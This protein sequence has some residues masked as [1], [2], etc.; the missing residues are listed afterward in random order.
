MPTAAIGD[1]ARPVTP[2]PARLASAGGLALAALLYAA[3]VVYG[4]LMPFDYRPRP[5]PEALAAFEAIPYLELGV[6]SRADWVANILLYIPLAFTAMAAWS[7]AAGRRRWLVP[8]GAVL[9]AGACVALA[10]AVEFAQL[11]FP[12][13]TVS[14]ND[15]I[16][17]SIG[18]AIGIAL[19]F[20]AGPRLLALLQGLRS[21]GAVAHRALLALYVLAYFALAFFPFDLLVSRQELADK[22]AD[23]TRVA[24]GVAG[25]C[26]GALVC[27]VKLGTELLIAAPIG[28]LLAL[29]LPRLGLGAAIAVGLALGAVVEAGQLLLASGVTQGVSVLTRAAG[30][31]WGLVLQHTLRLDWLER[32][33]R[34]VRWAVFGAVPAYLVLL[35][36]LNGFTGAVESGWA[37][38]AK[39]EGTR[40]LPFYYH[41]F[42]TETEAMWSLLANGAAYAVVGVGLWL[43]RPRASRAGRA[44]ALAAA[45]AAVVETVKLF[46]PGEKP[47]PTNVL[48][49]AAAAALVHAALVRL[50]SGVSATASSASD[51]TAAPGHAPGARRSSMPA[52]PTADGRERGLLWAGGATLAV[53]AAAGALLATPH[54][55]KPADESRLA[56]LPPGEALPP[57]VLPGFRQAHPR[58]PHPSPAEVARLLQEG[59]GY[60]GEQR[61]LAAQ[62]AANGYSFHARSLLELIEPGSQDLDTLHGQLMATRFQWRGHDQVR[63]LAV[64]YDWLH[65]RWTPEQREQ[66]RGKLAE[67]CEYLVNFIRSERLSPYNVYLY[68]APFQAL[69]ACS[70]A[71][72]GD[73]PRGEP[74]MRFTADLWLNRVLPAWRQVM[75]RNGGWHEGGEYVGIGIGNA[76]WEVPAMWRSA[77]GQD[78][79][80]D[81]PALCRF[82]DFLIHRTRPDG[83]HVKIGDGNYFDRGV[84]ARVPLAI[85]CRHPAAY[86][87]GAPNSVAPTAWPWGPLPVPW[88]QDAQ[89]LARQ[90]LA[91]HFDGIGWVVARSDW[92]PEAT[93]VTFKAGDHFWSHSHLDQGSFTIYKGG[94][95]A[96][97]SGANYG[98]R[99]GSDHHLNYSTQTIAHNAITVTDP[100]DTVP[101]PARERQKPRPIANDGGQRRIGSGWGIEPA[102]LDRAEWEAKR[103]TY[104]T[105]RIVRHA[106]QDGVTLAVADVT[107]AYTNSLSGQGT[108]SHRTRRVERAWRVF[109]YDRIDDVVVVYDDVVATEASFRKR[110]LLHTAFAPRLDGRLFVAEVPP[111]QGTGRAGGRLEGHVLLPRAATLLPVGG[112]GFEFMVDGVGYDD[113]GKLVEQIERL[114]P[115]R[116]EPGR[117]RLE[118]IPEADAAA[119]RFLVVMLP[120]HQGE[121]APHRVRLVEDGDRAG[122]EVAGP[123]RTVRYWFREGVL[124]AEVEVV[125][126][127][128]GTR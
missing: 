31:A 53:L 106:E 82:L 114:P 4:S 40:F 20:G 16:A 105:G 94:A 29:A 55:E 68:N 69:V 97:D 25:S 116:L 110:W 108:F 99:Y 57:V 24:W 42:T 15:L 78:L 88:L 80:A 65:D 34:A 107:P 3:F 92:G 7:V 9:V 56:Q 103:E 49:A 60:L 120:R 89:A 46:V 30:L 33:A 59:Q 51:A 38:A 111:A 28:A 77:T 47:D 52:P 96:L 1:A 37:A 10:V 2:G 84:P 73:D 121:P 17:E 122:A 12:P 83:T 13:R 119:D 117:W 81:E 19:W 113:G 109:A 66:L 98:T 104:H 112:R 72:W 54:A 115:H 127:G 36:V 26:G 62:K 45:L 61:R 126:S 41:Y 95:L 128:A 75:G 74:V 14:Q 76:I 22:L 27:T 125:A 87:M 23:P 43:L 11:F 101:I 90:P 58:L 8:P 70:L 35:L 123:T 102:P 44:A 50:S 18:T 71:L 118:V 86:S 93:Y 63:P 6:A 39:L 21:G 124:G 64:A 91:R 32:H 5:I 48:I 85:E 100:D 67:G 79:I